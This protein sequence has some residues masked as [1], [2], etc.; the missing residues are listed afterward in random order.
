MQALRD[1]DKA[2]ELNPQHHTAINIRGFLRARR[3]ESEGAT[4]DWGRSFEI[5]GRDFILA[6]QEYLISFGYYAGANDG[7][8]GSV[9]ERAM[10][11]CA[12]DPDC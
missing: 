9:M 4:R 8:Y 12:R 6:W 10:F 7:V 2:L 1:I 11:V 5:G 3:G